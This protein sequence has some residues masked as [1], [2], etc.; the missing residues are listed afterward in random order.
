MIFD[1]EKYARDFILG[2]HPEIKSIK[3]K[4]DLF[5][6]YNYFILHKTDEESYKSI[7]SWMKIHQNIFS[8]NNYAILIN[9]LIKK[10]PKHPFYHINNLIITDNEINIIT[11]QNNLRYEKILFILLCLAKLQ[12]QSLG[13][14]NGLVYYDIVE[15]FK[16][17]RVSVKASEREQILHDLYVQKLIDLPVKNSSKCLFVKYLDSNIIVDSKH[18]IYT[19]DENDSNELAYYYLKYVKNEKIVRCTKCHRLIKKNNKF[20]N[21]CSECLNVNCD[22][23]FIWCID[24]GK[25]VKID[26]NDSKTIRCKNC[27]L[28]QDKK[29]NLSRIKRYRNIE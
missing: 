27:Q 2:K 6:R 11:A 16:M 8:E 14:D 4:I 7:V 23:K 22:S 24:C 20:P 1:E 5:A 10:A 19:I 12:Q 9:D 18:L 28:I 13:F 26:K 21:I 15:L 17:A 3:Q 25:E 29:N